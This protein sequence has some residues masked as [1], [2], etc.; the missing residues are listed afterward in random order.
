VARLF[1]DFGGKLLSYYYIL[2]HF[3]GIAI[4]E[5]PDHQS[6]AACTMRAMASGAFSHF[7]TTMLMTRAEAQAAMARANAA[8]HGFVPPAG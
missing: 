4:A 3:D 5:F 1:A 2:G 7:E 8:A 6:I